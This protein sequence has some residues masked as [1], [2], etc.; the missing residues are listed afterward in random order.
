MVSSGFGM[1]FSIPTTSESYTSLHFDGVDYFADVYLTVSTWV[2][3]PAIS[4]HS[5]SMYP[6]Y[7]DPGR[8]SWLYESRVL[9]KHPDRMAG[10]Y[11]SALSRVYSTTT[12]A[13]LA[14]DGIRS[15]NPIT[16]VGSGT[17]SI[18][19]SMDR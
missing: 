3:I 17:A 10:I 18:S 11:A 14:V 12:T 4:I 16:P 6:A 13:V 19:K 8:I 7:F 2:T 1:N 5:P 15:A 9:M